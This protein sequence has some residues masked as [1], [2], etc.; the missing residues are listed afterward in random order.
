MKPFDFLTGFFLVNLLSGQSLGLSRDSDLVLDYKV[1]E[2][3]A[4]LPLECYNKE[5]PYKSSIVF[6][7]TQ[8]VQ[9][10]KRFY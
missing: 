9:V 8:D 5:F 6:N 10:L 1:A 7:G 3:L 2:E 4:K